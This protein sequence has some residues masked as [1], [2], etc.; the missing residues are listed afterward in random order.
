MR[1]ET[2]G[3][4]FKIGDAETKI[5]DAGV[6]VTDDPIEIELLTSLADADAVTIEEA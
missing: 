4:R 6:Y 2:G 3:V 5:V 1:V